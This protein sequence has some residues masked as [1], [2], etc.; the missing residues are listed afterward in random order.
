M[1]R[2]NS[3]IVSLVALPAVALAQDSTP[4]PDWNRSVLPI[5]QPEFR[6][7]VG[8]RV[9]ESTLDFPAEVTAPKGAPNILLIMPD[10]VGFGA[11]A[12]FGGPIPQPALDRR[13]AA[14]ERRTSF[15]SSSTRRTCRTNGL[16]THTCITNIEPHSGHTQR[17]SSG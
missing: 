11:T 10:D 16:V 7:K 12:P 4:E 13:S 6:G 2:F 17:S 1:N 9:S 8:L 15:T 14:A 3:L 5:P